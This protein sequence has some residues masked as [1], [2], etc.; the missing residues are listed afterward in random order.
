[1]NRR[2]RVHGKPVPHCIAALP[3]LRSAY[4]ISS[5]APSPLEAGNFWKQLGEERV[6]ARHEQLPP[7]QRCITA[8][9]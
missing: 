5:T 3:I 1:M 9:T 4:F 2:Q 7:K 6:D 8:C